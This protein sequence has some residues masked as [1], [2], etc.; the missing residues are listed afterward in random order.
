M[1]SIDPFGE[2]F[3][4]NMC[5]YMYV[6]IGTGPETQMFSEWAMQVISLTTR[7]S[8]HQGCL[9]HF[10][11]PL[12]PGDT[13]THTGIHA[14]RYT[15]TETDRDRERRIDKDKHKHKEAG[16]LGQEDRP[17]HQ[18]RSICMCVCV[19]VCSSTHVRVVS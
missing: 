9:G 13:H 4:I 10:A 11:T 17:T 18:T 6:Y 1:A 8:V 14:N 16:R 19:H 12:H 2:R 7:W 5:S 15:H 3:S